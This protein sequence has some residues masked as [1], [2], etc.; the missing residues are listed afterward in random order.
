MKKT[1]FIILLILLVPLLFQSCSSPLRG[2]FSSVRVI[3]D[4]DYSQLFSNP[5]YDQKVY[6]PGIEVI[7]QQVSCGYAVL[8]ML[9]QWQNMNL[10]ENM[11]YEMNNHSVTTA[12]GSGFVE[13]INRQ[14]PQWN[15][16][17]FVRCTNTD[18]LEKV[19]DSLKRGFP[20]PFEWAAKNTEG[21]WTLHF[22]LVVGLDFKNNIVQIANPYGYME[23][24][25]IQDFIKATRFESY[26]NME[27]YFE[28][29]F[30]FGLF[31]QNTVYV[32]EGK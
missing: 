21:N 17:R 11:L 32:I 25:S 31:N 5:D 6:V 14:F 15:V 13:E 24:F 10:T 18:L 27:W 22:S 30:N 29:G 7:T 3:V 8:Q 26:E 4:D 2:F 16:T 20:V 23:E 12:L 9:G 28:E 19:Y 1:N